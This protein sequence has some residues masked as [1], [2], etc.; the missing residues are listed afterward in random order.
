MYPP[1]LKHGSPQVHSM[2]FHG[3][4]IFHGRQVDL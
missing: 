4:A 1:V 2:I 3:S